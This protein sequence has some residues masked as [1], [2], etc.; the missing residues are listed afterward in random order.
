MDILWYLL[1][2]VGGLFGVKTFVQKSKI[3][4]LEKAEAERKAAEV[5]QVD[6]A[7]KRL[8]ASMQQHKTTPPDVKG[9]TDFENL[10]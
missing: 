1:I 3:N 8:N 5:A 4:K 10:K 6:L 9:R 7:I 2:V